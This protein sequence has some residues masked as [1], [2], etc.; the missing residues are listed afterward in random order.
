MIGDLEHIR[1]TQ[2]T[3]TEIAIYIRRFG[4]E[5]VPNILHRAL[6]MSEARIVMA[7]EEMKTQTLNRR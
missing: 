1:W 6:R 2:M 7:R 5:A 4:E 3:A